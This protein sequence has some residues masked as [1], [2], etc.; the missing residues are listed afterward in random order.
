MYR[1]HLYLTEELK[2]KL[3]ISARVSGKTKAEVAREALEKGLGE[4]KLPKSH[5]A[6]ALLE[7]TEMAKQLP[8]TNR[9][10]KDA[11]INMNYYTWGGEK[12]D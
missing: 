11:I 2:N 6:K 1:L 3:A 7:L 5:S 12:D 4:R 8:K 10:P 9:A